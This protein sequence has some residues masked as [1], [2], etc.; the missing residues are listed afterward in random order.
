MVVVALEYGLTRPS[1]HLDPNTWLPDV[2][3]SNRSIEVIASNRFFGDLGGRLDALVNLL[4]KRSSKDHLTVVD[5]ICLAEAKPENDIGYGSSD[6]S[7]DEQEISMM[8]SGLPG[9]R[10]T[11]G[12]LRWFKDKEGV[13]VLALESVAR[14]DCFDKVIRRERTRVL[15]N[16]VIAVTGSLKTTTLREMESSGRWIYPDWV[17]EGAFGES[18]RKIREIFNWARGRDAAVI[19]DDIDLFFS[20]G[21]RIGQDILGELCAELDKGGV[22]FIMSSDSLESLPDPLKLRMQH[23]KHT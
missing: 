6:S 19:W 21:G 5:W 9:G 20:A 1:Y 18:Q 4:K 15:V 3:S 7:D 23:H 10:F 8:T 13:L 14:S 22:R 16:E 12:L 17:V 11:E 2:L